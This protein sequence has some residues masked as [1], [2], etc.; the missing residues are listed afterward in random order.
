MTMEA[1]LPYIAGLVAF[2]A[3]LIARRDAHRDEGSQWQSVRDRL[4]VISDTT[5]DT[6]E[7][8]RAITRKLDDHAARLAKGEQRLDDIERRLD[9]A[10]L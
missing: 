1:M 5:R 3:F 4:D 9:K 8:V 6:R 10:D 2:V 7:D